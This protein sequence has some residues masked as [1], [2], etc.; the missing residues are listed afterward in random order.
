[1]K[2]LAI[3]GSTGSIG[4]ST[5]DVV[6]AHPDRLAVIGLAAGSNAERLLM[7]A[8]EFGPKAIGMAQMDA[9]R[10]VTGR[11]S[12]EVAAA[13][14]AGLVAV[15]THPEVD[16]V[17]CASSGTAA[18]HRRNPA[19]RLARESRASGKPAREAMRRAA[20]PAPINVRGSKR[21]SSRERRRTRATGARK[22]GPPGRNPARSATA[23][24]R[25]R[26]R[27]RR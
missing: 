13:G 5:L 24:R 2:R 9:L 17:I 11:Y 6:R 22:T 8:C 14:T 23:R 20:I 7:Q 21:R 15:A 3:L 27:C 25:S 26:E 12:A 1:M 4:Q 19:S 18:L 16:I 10:E